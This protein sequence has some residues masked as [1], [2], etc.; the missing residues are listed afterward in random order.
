VV[1]REDTVGEKRLVA[2]FVPM[3]TTAVTATHIRRG[4]ARVLPEYMIPGAIV[5]IDAMPQT[6]NGKTDRL[7]LPAPLRERPPLEIAFAAP[8][9]AMEGELL[10]IWSEVLDIDE[11]G[12]HDNFFELGGDSIGGLNVAERV[13]RAF[14]VEVPLRTIFESP[15][16][17][18]LTQAIR[19]SVPEV[20]DETLQGPATRVDGRVVS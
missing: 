5:C 13:W 2:Y 19:E 7:R 20:I 6:P 10:H 12:I 15:T 3:T 11:I 9:T 8:T 14:G 18:Q 4:L 1:G 16:V 17:F